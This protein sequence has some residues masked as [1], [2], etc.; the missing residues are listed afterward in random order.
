MADENAPL[1][2]S[3]DP[4]GS[5]ANGIRVILGR[6]PVVQ[7]KKACNIW[8]SEQKHHLAKL[9]KNRAA[10]LPKRKGSIAVATAWELVLNDLKGDAQSRFT[11]VDISNGKTLQTTFNRFRDE[12]LK[13]NGVTKD[14]INTSGWLA[15]TPTL[16]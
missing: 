7:P 15:W 13:A 6:N 11:N 10:H 12:V 4:A 8:S 5:V 2:N 14:A 3:A 16:I 9:V 1:F